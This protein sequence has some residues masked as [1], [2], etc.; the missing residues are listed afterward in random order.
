MPEEASKSSRRQV[1]LCNR[2]EGI[3]RPKKAGLESPGVPRGGCAGSNVSYQVR[4]VKCASVVGIGKNHV[5]VP[6]QAPAYCPCIQIRKCAGSETTQ[7]VSSTAMSTLQLIFGVDTS[8]IT[9][10]IGGEESTAESL[11]D[12]RLESHP[13]AQFPARRFVV[14]R[15]SSYAVRVGFL[16]QR[17]VLHVDWDI[18]PQFTDDKLLLLS[19]SNSEDHMRTAHILRIPCEES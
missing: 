11:E 7:R 14:P 3:R 13:F 10:D 9:I 16:E 17:V 4:V 1:P 5:S 6:K 19:L 15:S 8:D 2:T 18:G 12:R